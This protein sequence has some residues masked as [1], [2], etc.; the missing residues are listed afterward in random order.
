[1]PTTPSVYGELFET[2]GK[3]GNMDVEASDT[4]DTA[5]L[6]FPASS[7]TSQT[8][9]SQPLVRETGS[10]DNV[11]F[12]KDH[13]LLDVQMADTPSAAAQADAVLRKI[14]MLLHGDGS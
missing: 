7:S 10:I 3:S 1:M 4:F 12:P 5:V 6:D 11:E 14:Q 13:L 8:V 2:Q 9:P